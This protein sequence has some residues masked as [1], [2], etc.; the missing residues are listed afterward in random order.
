MHHVHDRDLAPSPPCRHGQ[1]QYD[2]GCCHRK[3]IALI[4]NECINSLLITSDN[5]QSMFLLVLLTP[6]TCL[7]LL[8]NSHG[9]RL[10]SATRRTPFLPCFLVLLCLANTV[11]A[12]EVGMMLSSWVTTMIAVRYCAANS[13]SMR[14]TVRER[15]LSSGAVG[16]SA[17][18]IGGLLASARAIARAALLRRTARKC[19]PRRGAPRPAP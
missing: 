14:I 2:S 11:K 6:S 9:Y 3:R 15:W 18:M 16:S 1:T 10:F 8:Y 12:L 5:C 13:L 17:R 19:A 7:L 4:K